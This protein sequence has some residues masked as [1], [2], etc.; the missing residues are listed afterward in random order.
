MATKQPIISD[1]IFH[2]ILQD[3][4]KQTLPESVE[5][6]YIPAGSKLTPVQYIPVDR[7]KLNPLNERFFNENKDEYSKLKQD[8]EKRG[9]I[10][11][12][13]AKRDET[14]LI[15]HRR[16]KIA[17]ELNFRTVPLQYI[18]GKLNEDEEKEF[19]IKDNVLRRQLSHNERIN[20]YRAFY[21]DFDQRIFIETR[22]GDRTNKGKTLNDPFADKGITIIELSQRTGVPEITVR[23]DLVKFRNSIKPQKVVKSKVPEKDSQKITRSLS[24]IEQAVKGKDKKFIK[25]VIQQIDQI[26]KKL[27]KLVSSSITA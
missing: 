10:V 7:L 4:E 11:P 15:G 18:E 24:K 3:N 22:G 19:I 23:R 20:I 2:K 16:L 13:I 6:S 14:L 12:L 5:L 9:I 17:I 26:K 27:Q 1:Q 8:I 21:P 25:N